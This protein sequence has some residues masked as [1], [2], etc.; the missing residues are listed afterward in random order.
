MREAFGRAMEALFAIGLCAVIL[1][2]LVALV[3]AVEW[4]YGHLRWPRS[5]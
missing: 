1:A 4:L 2:T 3:G 5:K